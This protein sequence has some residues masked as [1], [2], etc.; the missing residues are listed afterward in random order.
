VQYEQKKEIP[1]WV[2]RTLC[3][4]GF[5]G[6]IVLGIVALALS[7]R[8]GAEGTTTGILVM[9]LGVGGCWLTREEMKQR[10]EPISKRELYNSPSH[11]RKGIRHEPK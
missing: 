7:V 1:L 6:S 10:F 11:P 3:T 9:I 4:I 2:F 5:G 8:V